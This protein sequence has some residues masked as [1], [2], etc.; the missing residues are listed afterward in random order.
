VHA[1]PDAVTVPEP[2]PDEPA[3]T[4]T[5]NVGGGAKLASTVVF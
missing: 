5:R 4:V 1:I 3:T 2:V